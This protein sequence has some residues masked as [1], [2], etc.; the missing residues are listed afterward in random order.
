[1]FSIICSVNVEPVKSTL[2]PATSK[3]DRF[4]SY[5]LNAKFEHEHFLQHLKQ[6]HKQDK[7]FP[8]SIW[9]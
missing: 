2:L 1:M 4:W 8:F 6:Q 9:F 7:S 5:Q 3:F